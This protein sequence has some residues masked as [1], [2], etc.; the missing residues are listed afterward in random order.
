MCTASTLTLLCYICLFCHS[1]Y[2]D[3]GVSC[4]RAKKCLRYLAKLGW[5]CFKQSYLLH[6]QSIK[7]V[8]TLSLHIAVLFRKPNQ[9]IVHRSGCQRKYPIISIRVMN[10]F[11][12]VY[13]SFFQHPA[14]SFVLTFSGSYTQPQ[15]NDNWI[16]VRTYIGITEI[17]EEYMCRLEWWRKTKTNSF[18][19]KKHRKKWTKKCV[20]GKKGAITT[21]TSVVATAEKKITRKVNK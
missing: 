9:T 3:S 17:E 15:W 13:F 10:I 1:I 6:R 16:C 14:L 5:C 11:F 20:S 7:A 19:E 4:V 2:F 18:T 12:F 21:V 8:T